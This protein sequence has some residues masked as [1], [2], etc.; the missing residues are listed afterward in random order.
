MFI[1]AIRAAK[2]GQI[3][4]ARETVEEG[5]GYFSQGHHSHLELISKEASGERTEIS[6]LLIH[7][8][9]MLM[10]AESFK[11]LALEFIDLYEKMFKLNQAIDH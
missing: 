8:E 1:E 4:E 7:T 2:E 11:I 6:L 3:L 10:S 5:L 9:D